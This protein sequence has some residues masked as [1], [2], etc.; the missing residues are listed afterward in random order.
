A[1]RRVYESTPVRHVNRIGLHEPDVA[2]D[3]AALIPPSLE[4]AGVGPDDE[5]VA[6]ARLDE[7]RD[8]VAEARVAAGVVADVLAVQPYV[9]VAVDAVEIQEDPP[10]T[11]R[12]RQREGFA[13]P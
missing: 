4:M 8:V 10:A 5:Q 9:A 6:R 13:V 3:S 12:C 1:G 7:R 2:V 11:I